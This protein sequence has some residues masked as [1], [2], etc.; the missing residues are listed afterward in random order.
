MMLCTRF[1]I[2]AIAL[3]ALGVLEG[4]ARADA[5]RDELCKHQLDFPDFAELI[6]DGSRILFINIALCDLDLSQPSAESRNK[7]LS[8]L[9]Y[10]LDRPGRAP[11]EIVRAYFLYLCLPGDVGAANAPFRYAM[12]NRDGRQLDK[13]AFDAEVASLKMNAYGQK[14]AALLWQAARKLAD[15]HEA[16]VRDLTKSDAALKAKLVDVPAKA[17]A[18]ADAFYQANKSAI[19]AAIAVEDKA[20][21][22][23]PNQLRNPHAIG[24]CDALHD[25]L[26]AFVSSKGPKT[27][28]DVRAAFGE[29]LGY[30]LMSRVALCDAAEG[31]WYAAAAENA[32]LEFV[33]VQHGPRTAAY[34]ASLDAWKGT[35]DEQIDPSRWQAWREATESAINPHVTTLTALRDDPADKDR[36]PYNRKL[37]LGKIASMKTTSEGVVVTFKK[38]KWIEPVWSCEHTGQIIQ[39]DA[40]GRPQYNYHCKEVGTEQQEWELGPHVVDVRSAR[41]LK[42]GQIVKVCSME[43]KPY[44]TGDQPFFGFVFEVAELAKGSK[45]GPKPISAWGVSLGGKP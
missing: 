31:R 32:I 6:D 9:L 8:H 33:Q 38:E 10:Y 37:K 43:T 40:S 13:R 30:W 22:I 39:Y 41:G 28:D 5:A 14:Q 27:P 12:C 3:V 1:A 26:E 15:A 24:G 45:S 17:A 2:A 19:D 18:D 11:S 29:P 16:H 42:V 4:S 23:D 25:K 35:W 44:R 21:A 7:K 34:N 20:R 36:E